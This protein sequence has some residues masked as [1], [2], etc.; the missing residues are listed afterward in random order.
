MM[1]DILNFLPITETLFSGGM[2]TVEQVAD[3]ARNGVKLVINLA[4][5]EPERDLKDEGALVRSVG[6]DYLNI[7]VDW[8]A[9]K[10]QDLQAFIRAMDDNRDRK[11]LVHCRANYRATGFIAL[12]RILK[13]GWDP[14]EA[15]K[16][17]LSIWNPEDYPVWKKFIADNL[18]RNDPTAKGES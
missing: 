9:P 14:E 5:Y 17:L 8:E 2:P 15:F 6:M 7:P 10:R 11:V 18:A 16:Y 1:E 4:P 13:L 12:Y 3:V